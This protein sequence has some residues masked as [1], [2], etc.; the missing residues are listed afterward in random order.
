MASPLYRRFGHIVLLWEHM[1][2]TQDPPGKVHKD[3][4]VKARKCDY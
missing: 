4:L 3:L 1:N 2:N